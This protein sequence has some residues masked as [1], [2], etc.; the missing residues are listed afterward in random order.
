MQIS[1]TPDVF[2]L[3]QV[4]TISRGSRTEAKVLTVKVEEDGHVGWGECVPYARYG[5]TLENVTQLIE[6]V[7]GPVTRQGLYTLPAGAARNALDCALWDLECKKAGKRAWELAGLPKPGPEITAYTLSLAEPA[8]MQ[9]QAA[10]NAHRPLLKIKLGTPDDMA[11]LEA[12]R[13]GAPKSTIIVDA[14]EGWSA[15]VYADLA[16][17]L[18]RLGVALVEQPLPAGDDDA[19]IGM[20]RPVPVCADESA[21]DCSTLSKLK[22]KYDVVNIKLDKTG[23]LT[24]AL[25][26]REAALAEGYKVMVGC[27][28]GSSL[29]MAPATLVAQGAMVTDLDGPLLLAEDRDTPLTFDEDGVHPPSAALWG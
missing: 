28:V 14:N 22:G 23:G 18:V 21:H 10:K 4:F 8:E 19:L 7:K 2:K 13:A 11:R 5:E 16:P 27:M 9:A 1:V 20:E 12:V 25:K 6:S 17:H 26:L 29:A 24:E 3:A 15:E